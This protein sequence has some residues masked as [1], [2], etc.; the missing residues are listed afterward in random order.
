MY[1]IVPCCLFLTKGFALDVL[2]TIGNMV[3]R[4]NEEFLYSGL[5]SIP[6]KQALIV[7]L[8]TAK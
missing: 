1:L 8:G 7:D 5:P 4:R 3:W 2:N 6:N